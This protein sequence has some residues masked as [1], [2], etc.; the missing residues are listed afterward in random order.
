MYICKYACRVEDIKHTQS[1]KNFP[2]KC[3][4]CMMA[5]YPQYT[6]DF[7]LFLIVSQTFLFIELPREFFGKICMM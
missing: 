7:L 1:G 6:Q 5:K 3:C 2:F 4:S